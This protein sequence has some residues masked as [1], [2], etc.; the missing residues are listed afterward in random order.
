M[1]YFR[2]RKAQEEARKLSHIQREVAILDNLLTADVNVIRS[3]IELASREFLDAQYV[4][5]L[6]ID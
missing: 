4:I 5:S 2:Q 3:R 1:T 6:S